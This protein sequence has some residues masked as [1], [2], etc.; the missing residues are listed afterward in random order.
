MNADDF[1]KQEFTSGRLTPAH[2][3]ALVREF[4]RDQGFSGNTGPRALDGKAGKGTRDAIDAL[5]KSRTQVTAPLPVTP[6]LP[7]VLTGDKLRDL[8]LKVVQQ[9]ETLWSGSIIDPPDDAA[10]WASSRLIIDRMIRSPIGLNWSWYKEYIK[11]GDYEWCGA[12]AATCWAVAGLLLP[13]RYSFWSST[14]RLEQWSHYRPF[15]STSSGTKP[16]TGGRMV[17]ELNTE[18][19]PSHAVFPDGTLPREGD[20]VMVGMDKSGQ[21]THITIAGSYDATTGTF[22]TIEGNGTGI[23]PDGTKQHGVI[24]AIRRIGLQPGQSPQT[25]HVRRVIRPGLADCGL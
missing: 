1:N 12:F 6:R 5:V 21:G 11:N 17:I 2:L 13:W 23:W 24:K 3:T 22:H 14:F 7:I 16:A 18:S 4:Q 20:V 25:Y 15:E 9:A 10:K 8:G 19:K